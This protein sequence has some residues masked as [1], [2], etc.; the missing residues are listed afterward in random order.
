MNNL[1]EDEKWMRRCLTLARCGR[2]GAPPNP[3]VGSVVMH[4]GRIIGEGYHIRCGTA[5]AE[6]NAIINAI[7]SDREGA[8]LY[9]V[10]LENGKRIERPQ[11]C[12]LCAKIIRNAQIRRVES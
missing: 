10:G 3:M 4:G 9:L 12:E 5:H 7:P 6:V 2:Y 11:P 1:Q 8:T